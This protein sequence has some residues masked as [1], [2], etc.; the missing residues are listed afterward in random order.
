MNSMYNIYHVVLGQR[1][2]SLDSDLARPI[3]EIMCKHYSEGT[4]LDLLRS[5]KHIMEAKLASAKTHYEAYL[6]SNHLVAVELDVDMNQDQGRPTP[7]T[8]PEQLD[9]AVCIFNYL[10][11]QGVADLTTGN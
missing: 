8:A 4:I 10:Y 9:N 7:K 1:I 3:T 11:C 6:Q 5:E 2:W